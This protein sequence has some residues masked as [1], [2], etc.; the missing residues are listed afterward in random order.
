MHKHYD[1]ITKRMEQIIKHWRTL[2]LECPGKV[3]LANTITMAP[4]WHIAGQIPLH[5]NQIK[6]LEKIIYKFIWSSDIE[7][8]KRTVNQQPEKNG[9]LG[10]QDIRTKQKSIW[11]KQILKIIGEPSSPNRQE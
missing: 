1:K 10:V 5:K 4:L 8:I 9:G 7:P 11:T 3:I 6:N 2:R